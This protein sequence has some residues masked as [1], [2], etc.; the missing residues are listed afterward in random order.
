MEA[1]LGM[2]SSTLMFVLWPPLLVKMTLSHAGAT[3]YSG[4]EEGFEQILRG[5]HVIMPA[6]SAEAHVVASVLVTIPL[7]VTSLLWV[8]EALEG[9]RELLESLVRPW[10]TALVGVKLQR[11]LAVCF[12][13]NIL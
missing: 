13:G 5:G 12:L 8:A 4:A 10:R 6:A 7:V 9:S 11:Q 1:L 3:K 2:R